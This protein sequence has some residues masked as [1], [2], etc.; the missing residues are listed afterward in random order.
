M[1]VAC[2]QVIDTAFGPMKREIGRV[3]LI[4]KQYMAR[5][6]TD[7][8]RVSDV[9]PIDGNRRQIA[10]ELSRNA[11]AMNHVAA[12]VT[13]CRGLMHGRTLKGVCDN[14]AQRMK[15]HTCQLDHLTFP[16]LHISHEPATSARKKPRRRVRA[17][18]RHLPQAART[19]RCHHRFQR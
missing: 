1:K 3:A 14:V 18:H 10:A 19:A 17:I 16:R 11:C 9:A 12:V 2:A 5:C 7:L 6:V 8:G 4:R 13:L 15:S